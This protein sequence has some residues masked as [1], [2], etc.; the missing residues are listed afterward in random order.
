MN[1]G[2]RTT[3]RVRKTSTSGRPSGLEVGHLVVIDAVRRLG[4]VTAAA[5]SLHLSQPAISHT[6][7]EIER[8][9]DVEVVRPNGR[10]IKV[11][12]AGERLARHARTI[13]DQ[14]I[15]AEDDVR[16][17]AEGEGS[18]LRLTTECYTCYHWLPRAI[19]QLR[20]RLPRLQLQLVPEATYRSLEALR[21]REVDLAIVSRKL[22]HP[23][24]EHKPL[25]HDEMVA[26]VPPG[27]PYAGRPFITA[28]DFRD[29]HL[30]LHCA[31][32]QSDVVTEV[33]TPAG[34][35]PGRISKVPVTEAVL[36]TVKAGLGITAMARWAV[37]NQLRSGELI[38][39]P[40]TENGL[41]R[42]WWIAY[43]RGM[44]QRP[45]VTELIE[46]LRDNGL[47]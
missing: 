28:E 2:D 14:M 4:S 17:L 33:L 5:S 42:R 45:G 34:V 10:G 26:L 25:F 31:P 15:A 39:I 16:S 19:A 8:R 6:L 44:G 3:G 21:A 46:L 1:N 12:A 9:L 43:P 47:E 13:L 38:A 40:L 20:H 37:V 30:V 32:E 7:R 35:A 22:D 23:E 27:H 18:R 24:I 11:T 36:E 29:Q 41:I